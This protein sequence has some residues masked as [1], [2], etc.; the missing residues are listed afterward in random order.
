[1]GAFRYLSCIVAMLLMIGVGCAS[2]GTNFDESNVGS[3]R[4][5]VTG[6]AELTEWFGPPQNRS[7]SSGPV[8]GIHGGV[9][10]APIAVP[11]TS[12]G[13]ASDT[14]TRITLTWQYVEGRVNGKSFIPFAGAFM[15][16]HNTSHKILFVVLKDGV[17]ES[18]SSSAGG[19]ESRNG[20]QSVPDPIDLEKKFK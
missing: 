2:S 12:P 15:G 16:G 19:N 5:G 11:S 14:A 20:V 4:K 3:I 13:T 10:M 18:Y 9:G 6:E 17:V 1:M 7:I 8:T